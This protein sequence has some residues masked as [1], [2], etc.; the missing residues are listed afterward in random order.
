MFSSCTNKVFSSEIV[1]YINETSFFSSFYIQRA[2]IQIPKSFQRVSINKSPHVFKKSKER[3]I[4]HKPIKIHF[5]TPFFSNS[6]L[7]N[8]FLKAVV[9]YLFYLSPNIQIKVINRVSY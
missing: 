3:F 2:F 5:V 1:F 9:K 4:I 6:N 7:L 8:I